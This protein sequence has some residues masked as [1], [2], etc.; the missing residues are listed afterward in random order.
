MSFPSS[1]L[2]SPLTPFGCFSSIFP[3]PHPPCL[4]LSS[5]SPPMHPPLPPPPP[6][7]S[8]ALLFIAMSSQGSAA[9]KAFSCCHYNYSLH[10]CTHTHPHPWTRMHTHTQ[11]RSDSTTTVSLCLHVC[12]CS[13]CA[14]IHKRVSY[15]Y[16]SPSLSSSPS[17]PHP[18]LPRLP[19]TFAMLSTGSISRAPTS[20]LSHT[21][22]TH[23]RV[24]AAPSVSLRFQS[25]FRAPLQPSISANSQLAHSLVMDQTVAQV[26]LAA[27]RHVLAAVQMTWSPLT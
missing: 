2:P 22:L 17:P 5:P 21:E 3:L 18:S 12:A 4:P 16:L 1:P 9:T 14:V 13:A 26:A 15:F 24:K 23:E 11:E 20:L 6:S 25:Y 27:P 19:A 10:T 7:L 8:V